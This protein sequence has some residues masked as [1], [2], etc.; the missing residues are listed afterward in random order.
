MR[1]TAF[2]AATARELDD[3][4]AAWLEASPGIVVAFA[5]QSQSPVFGFGGQTTGVLITLT[6]FYYTR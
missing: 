2:S 6:V 5:T 1:A 3:A 4:L